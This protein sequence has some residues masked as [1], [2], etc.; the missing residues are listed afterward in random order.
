MQELLVQLCLSIHTNSE[1]FS[2]DYYKNASDPTTVD[3]TNDL[4]KKYLAYSYYNN[5]PSLKVFNNKLGTAKNSSGNTVVNDSSGLKVYLNSSDATSLNV[6][7]NTT[8]PSKVMIVGRFTDTSGTNNTSFGE[9]KLDGREFTVSSVKAESN[10]QKYLLLSTT[11]TDTVNITD[12]DVQIF[13]TEATDVEAFFEGGTNVFDGSTTNF[14]SS[15]VVLRETFKHSYKNT[16]VALESRGLMV[17]LL[18]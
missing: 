16:D 7:D 2:F 8:W 11:D 6:N 15:K 4:N 3:T 12:T 13:H 5:S 17:V 1:V 9:A 14:S 10:G 18:Q